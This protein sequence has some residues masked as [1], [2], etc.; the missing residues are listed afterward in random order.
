ME[1]GEQAFVLVS[2]L[3]S[4][5]SLAQISFLGNQVGA[6]KQTRMCLHQALSDTRAAGERSCETK[7]KAEVE[8]D[9]VV[10]VVV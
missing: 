6:R 2:S 5:L 3:G 4:G 1:K 7:A 10:V 8:E 9:R